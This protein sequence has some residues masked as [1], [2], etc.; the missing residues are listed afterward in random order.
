MEEGEQD[1][2]LDG[3]DQDADE[4]ER[5]RR[6]GAGPHRRNPTLG[7][8]KVPDEPVQVEAVEVVHVAVHRDEAL[9]PG[10]EDDRGAVDHGVRDP[11]RGGQQPVEQED[12]NEGEEE[13]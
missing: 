4:D 7:R 12:R 8:D 10:E 13:E 11:G 5:Q 3:Q 6:G 2:R 1:P 9:D